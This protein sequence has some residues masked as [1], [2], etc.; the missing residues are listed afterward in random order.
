MMQSNGHQ[1]LLALEIDLA[2]IGIGNRIAF[3]PEMNGEHIH[4]QVSLDCGVV[5][6]PPDLM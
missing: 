3:Q 6:L 1:Q 2:A 4:S 5:E